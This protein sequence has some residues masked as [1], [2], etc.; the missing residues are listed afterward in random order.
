[1]KFDENNVLEDFEFPVDGTS[2]GA[3]LD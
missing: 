2:K 1:M 3:I